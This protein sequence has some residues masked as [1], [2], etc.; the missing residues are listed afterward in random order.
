VP[1]YHFCHVGSL[2]QIADWAYGGKWG[3]C[4]VTAF[5]TARVCV[6][7]GNAAG[8]KRLP[9]HACPPACLLRLHCLWYVHFDYWI[10]QLLLM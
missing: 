9:C 4:K 10:G 5:T 7:Q 8:R 1:W 3:G 6:G 2:V